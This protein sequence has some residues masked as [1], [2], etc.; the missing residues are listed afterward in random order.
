MQNAGRDSVVAIENEISPPLESVIIVG[1][2]CV[3]TIKKE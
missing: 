3:S 1:K 2:K